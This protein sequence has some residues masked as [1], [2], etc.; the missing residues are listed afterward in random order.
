M[1]QSLGVRQQMDSENFTSDRNKQPEKT[2]PISNNFEQYR[3]ALRLSLHLKSRLIWKIYSPQQQQQQQGNVV[4]ADSRE[5]WRVRPARLPTHP[6]THLS[7]L[8]KRL[9]PRP[10]T[11]SGPW[12]HRQASAPQMSLGLAKYND[13]IIQ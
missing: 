10:E 8:P 7:E 2:A 11:E 12:T 4:G 9:G 5:E 1:R 3:E 6:L 13:S